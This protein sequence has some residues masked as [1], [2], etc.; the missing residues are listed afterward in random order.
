M[1]D[2]WL[3]RRYRLTDFFL[4]LSQNLGPDR[5]AQVAGL[6][7]SSR[8]ELMTHAR[9]SQEYE[10]LQSDAFLMIFRDVHKSTYKLML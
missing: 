4:A 8:V 6:S 3:A 5:L 10:C 1:V 7:R 2:R 9:D